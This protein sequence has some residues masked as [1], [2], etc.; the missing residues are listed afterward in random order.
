MRAREMYWLYGKSFDGVGFICIYTSIR[1]IWAM[2]VKEAQIFWGEARFPKIDLFCMCVWSCPTEIHHS[3][4]HIFL[5]ESLAKVSH[6][7]KSNMCVFVLTQHVCICTEYIYIIVIYIYRPITCGSTWRAS[8]HFP[9]YFTQTP[10]AHFPITTPPP[11]KN[12]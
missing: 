5:G 7:T 10:P 3:R 6:K 11:S 1:V 2:R 9:V 12:T 4:W 8:F